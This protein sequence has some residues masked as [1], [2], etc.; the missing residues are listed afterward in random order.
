[1]LRRVLRQRAVVARMAWA[2]FRA[3]YAGTALGTLWAVL[4]PLTTLAVYVFVFSVGFRSAPVQDAPY[5][6]WLFCAM[7]PWFFFSDVLTGVTD[8]LR[9]YAHLVRKTPFDPWLLPAVRAG[10]ALPAHGVCWLLL[11]G[12][13]LCFGRSPAVLWAQSAYYSL[14]ALAVSMGLGV[15]FCALSPFLKDVSQAVGILLQL[16]FWATPLA[17]SA[18]I[19]SEGVQKILK[20]TPMFYVVQGYRDSFRLG[21]DPAYFWQKPAWSL[22]FWA[23]TALLWLGALWTFRKLR[24]RFADAL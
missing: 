20:L 5:A 16:G 14:C 15:F 1:M 23:V 22:Y 18:D 21:T 19:M 11:A 13:A 8:A 17:W 3:R 9:Q 6:L 24:P 10:G 2:D 4:Q 7:T 12:S